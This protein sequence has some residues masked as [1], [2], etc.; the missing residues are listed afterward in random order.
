MPMPVSAT[1][2]S[3]IVGGG[4]ADAP[5]TPTS[6]LPSSALM[7]IVPC[8]GVYLMALS[9]RFENTCPRRSSSPRMGGN[10]AGIF[11]T[12]RC[13]FCSMR[14]RRSPTVRSM[15]PAR[16]TGSCLSGTCPHCYGTVNSEGHQD[17]H[18]EDL[19]VV[20]HRAPAGGTGW[21]SPIRRR[22]CAD[23]LPSNGGA[24]PEHGLFQERV[25]EGH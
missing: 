11:T 9:R 7:L 14:G 13:C 22:A 19:V 23:D 10:S 21:P 12:T 3:I 6:P 24:G 16:A 15:R 1:L 20:V 4:P 8:S 18:A 5:P 25:I 2:T 17:L